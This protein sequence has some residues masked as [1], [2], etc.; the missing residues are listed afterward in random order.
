MAERPAVLFLCVHNAGRSQMALGWFQHLAGD[1]AVGWSGGSEPGDE[2]NPSAVEAMREVG[3]DISREFPKP[4][5][6]QAVR[7]ADVVVTMGC[8]D[9]CPVFPGKRYEDW[10]L[11]D[12][13]GLGVDAVRPIRDA[14]ER[15][16]RTLLAELG[17]RP[18]MGPAVGPDVGPAVGPDVGP[19]VGPA[20][21][22]DARL[23][24]SDAA[25]SPVGVR[26]MRVEDWPAVAEVYAEGI[27][28]GDATFETEVPSWAGWDAAHLPDHRLV[29]EVD[30]TV[31]G[32]TAVSPV[33]GRCVYAGVVED[34][35]YVAESARGRGVGRRL[36][37]ALVESTENAG[38]WTIQ[39][40][41]FPENES[42]LALHRAAGFRVL[43]V[44]ERPG[45]LRG[46]WRDVVLLE[47]R[48]TVAGR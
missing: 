47:R 10:T 32:W 45:Q 44:R 9:A 22:L 24:V 33:S 23:G 12:P 11:D 8:G 30:G 42:S 43:G 41:I 2:V 31:V 35:V 39:T 18:A 25:P 28:G 14:I 48:S 5:T 38:I 19:A 1:R 16:V 15:R 26:P 46:R 37:A 20:D 36:L 29:A 6:E 40:G 3:I 34:S 4:W 7:S 27:A 17:V 13:A 21:R